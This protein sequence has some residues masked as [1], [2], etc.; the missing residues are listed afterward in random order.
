M[1][2]IASY[3]RGALNKSHSSTISNLPLNN[4]ADNKYERCKYQN[5]DEKKW[6]N[7]KKGIKKLIFYLMNAGLI[8]LSTGL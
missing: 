1:E 5:F 8:N 4:L 7:N 3:T 6:H 2:E